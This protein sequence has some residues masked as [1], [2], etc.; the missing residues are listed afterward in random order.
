MAKWDE[1]QQDFSGGEVG[2]RFIMRDDTAAHGKSALKMLNFIP[3]LQGTAVRTPGST[4]LQEIDATYARIIPYITPT[5]AK[6]L[7]VMKPAVGAV[8][9]DMEIIEGID[10]ATNPSTLSSMRALD[11]LQEIR[12]NVVPNGN[13][14][15]F[16]PWIMS[17]DG[18]YTGGNGNLLGWAYDD[19]IFK[20]SPRDWKYP[21][22]ADTIS[23]INIF[24]LPADLVPA[25][26]LILNAHITYQANRTS[27]EL[28]GNGTSVMEV[29]VGTGSDPTTGL[30]F[31]QPLNLPVGG[32]WD[33][34]VGVP[35]QVQPGDVMWIQFITTAQRKDSNSISDPI[36]WLR[37]L[38]LVG[39]VSRQVN[40]T[41]L[42]ASVPYTEDELKDVQF[43]QSPYPGSAGGDRGKELV[44][45]HP[46]YTPKRLYFVAPDYVFGDIFTDDPSQ[47]YG[48]FNWDTQGYPAACTSFMG[49]LVLGGSTVDPFLGSSDGANTETVWATVVGQWNKFTTTPA[50]ADYPVDGRAILATDSVTFTAIYRSPIKWLAGQKQLLVG[51]E[52]MEYTASA[53]GI[54]QVGDLGVEMQTTHGSSSVQ[55]V[56]MGQ[57]VVF[58]AEAG[59]KLRALQYLEDDKGWVAP[60]LTLLHPELF[61]SGIVR[62]VRMRNPMQLVVVVKGDGDVAILSQDTYAQVQGWSRLSL[63][64]NVIDAA[65][66]TDEN[67]SDVLYLL[68]RRTDENGAAV[69]YL[70]AISNWV[71][72]VQYR[73]VNSNALIINASTTNIIGTPGDPTGQLGHLEGQRVQVV[74]DG[75][76]LG[77]YLVTNYAV[78][79]I[80]DAGL[81]IQVQTALVGLAMACQLDTLPLITKDPGSK[82]RYNKITVRTLNSS[83]P[84]I[85]GERPADRDP[86]TF[87]NQSQYR[88]IIYDNEVAVLGTTVGQVISV[89]ETVPIRLEVTGIFGAV[90]G[91]EL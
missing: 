57:Y 29:R 38:K 87:Q 31:T 42:L 78:I 69:L 52:S 41:P 27:D 61:S 43:V 65:V 10:A 56:G 19:K 71:E 12:T 46:N 22:E 6:A 28:E 16:N 62:M 77:T 37:T 60:D 54:F 14:E 58:P 82:K 17:P 49:R 80:D 55:P 85:N 40:T 24:T 64:G 79:L 9:G 72:G 74:G 33:Q 91:D 50:Y 66:L 1:L 86:S 21:E 63:G 45:V 7:V 18:Q 67:G 83:R 44:M 47:H 84:M 88:D 35:G 68:I 2:P 51:A 26:T 70:E 48:Q 90:K 11:T 20:G 4:F 75:Q 8:Q 23:M 36:M 25:S 39:L 76:F 15:G 81:P 32:R 59:T 30:I 34:T 89:T 3:T 73:Y 13:L 53:D 5:N